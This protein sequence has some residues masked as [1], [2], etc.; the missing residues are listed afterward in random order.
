MKPFP[1]LILSCEHGGNE[2]PE[3]FHDALDSPLARQYLNSHRG[4]DPG[5]LEAA[6]C[7]AKCSGACLVHSTTS[8]LLI[9]LNRSLDHAQ[10]FSRFT[11]SIPAD[12]RQAII[13]RYYL[14]YRSRIHA[15]LASAVKN[16]SPVV[17][18]SVHSFTPV[19]RGVRRNLEIGL[20]FD[21][22]RKFETTLCLT[23]QRVLRSLDQRLRVE[24]NQP[25]LG[26]DDGLTT[27]LRRQFTDR[28]Y[29]GIELEINHRIARRSEPS[30]QRFWRVLYESLAQTL[31]Q[32]AV[33]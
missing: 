15:V 3:E 7:F 28:Q 13:D 20:L 14:P 32:L 10:L 16:G 18:C 25:Y 4:W 31:S 26:I 27:A 5:S 9:D 21:P 11:R 12:A 1:Q 24:L 23:W 33:V 6:Q 17:H 8:R 2:V 29:A 22:D 19:F 30:R